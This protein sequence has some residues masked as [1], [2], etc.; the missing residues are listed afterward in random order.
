MKTS[1]I[2]I[3]TTRTLITLFF[4]F[5]AINTS[6]QGPPSPPTN[7]VDDTATPINFYWFM[8]LIAGAYYG[9]KKLR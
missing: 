6:A 3:S 7:G 5:L 2:K 8:L 4:L 1:F 9:V